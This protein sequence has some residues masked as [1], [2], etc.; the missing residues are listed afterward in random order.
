MLGEKG[1]K[2]MKKIFG[3]CVLVF[4]MVFVVTPAFAAP[5]NA[6]NNP[7]I[8]ANFPSGQHTVIEGN[9]VTDFNHV[10]SDVVMKAGNSNNFQQWFQG[11]STT[12]SQA[13]AHGDH[14]VWRDIGSNTSCPSG[15]TF[16]ANPKQPPTGDTWGSYFPNGDNYCVHTNDSH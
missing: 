4:L 9:G 5:N 1:V 2:Y 11:S 8:V 13:G 12:E 7:N 14:S 15:W 3:T 16:V 6:A 10:G